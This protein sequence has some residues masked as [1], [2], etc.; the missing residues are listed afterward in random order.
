MEKSLHIYTEEKSFEEFAR[1][2]LPNII[3]QTQ[4]KIYSHQGKSDME[5]AL[6]STL[7]IISRIPGA[8]VIITRD[9][10]SGNCMNLKQT[11]QDIVSHNCF[12]EFKIRIV[13]RELE[14]W[15]LGDLKAISKAYPRFKP[16]QYV[17]KSD[18]KTIDTLD[19][20]DQLLLRIIPELMQYKTLPKMAFAKNVAQ[21]M[22]VD[23]NK[24][25]SFQHFVKAVK[26][27]TQ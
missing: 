10:D 17:N 7:P 23:N 2:I 18:F 25:V 21:Y 20:T 9:Q 16:E 26:S 27:L 3:K 12:S 22:N 24:S 5:K 11:L 14:C 6:R 19:G 4:L 13:C 1:A 15:L 8:K